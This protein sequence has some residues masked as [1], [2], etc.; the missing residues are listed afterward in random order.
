MNVSFGSEFNATQTTDGAAAE[1]KSEG[2]APVLIKQLLK[3]AEGN[4]QMFGMTFSMVC[5][6]TIVRNIETS[7][8]KI[9]YLL[10]D[11]TG[12]ITAHYWLE[13]G[14]TLKAPDVM[15]N[16]YAT[17]YGSVRS[18]GGQKTIMVFKMLPINDPNEIVTHVLEVLCARYKAE[19]Y[20]SSF[21]GHNFVGASKVST[22]FDM[23]STSESGLDGKKLAVLQAIKTHQSP[24]GINRNELKRKFQQM[25]ESELN[26]ILDFMITEGFIYSSIDADHFLSTE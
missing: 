15:L 12:Q 13:E 6:R 24:D 16:K 4:F 19:Q 11:N 8:T 22:G 2:I 20:A 10:E 26:S 7:S 14:D 5:V 23:P 17:V 18:Q 1:K 21:S 3:S 9:T 25:K